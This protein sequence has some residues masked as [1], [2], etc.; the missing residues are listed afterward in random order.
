MYVWFHYF[1][2]LP[3]LQ[4]FCL[5][6]LAPLF[7]KSFPVTDLCSAFAF[8][9]SF[10]PPLLPSSICPFSGVPQLDKTKFFFPL[11]YERVLYLWYGLKTLPLA[12]SSH[13]QRNLEKFVLTERSIII[14]EVDDL[15]HFS[16]AA[17]KVFFFAVEV[18][19]RSLIIMCF[20]FLWI[21]FP[22][23]FI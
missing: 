10:L 23:S 6:I 2:Q 13:L 4:L 18:N 12:F 22:L 14:H 8:L 17:F 9:I 20:G 7:E 3:A 5:L 16:L 15:H 1:L 19:F 21:N 11:A